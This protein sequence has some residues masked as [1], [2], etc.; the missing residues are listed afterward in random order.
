M[1]LAVYNQISCIRPSGALPRVLPAKLPSHMPDMSA[2]VFHI[3]VCSRLL[4]LQLPGGGVQLQHLHGE[5]QDDQDTAP[6]RHHPARRDPQVGAAVDSCTC[7]FLMPHM[8]HHHHE[9]LINSVTCSCGGAVAPMFLQYRT[10]AVPWRCIPCSIMHS[11]PLL[12]HCLLW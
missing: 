10:L 5:G 7:V 1:C 3:L 11:S 9:M 2:C 8:T 4:V 6:A 12:P